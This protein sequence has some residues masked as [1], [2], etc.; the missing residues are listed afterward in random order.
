MAGVVRL[1]ALAVAAVVA[2]SGPSAVAAAPAQSPVGEQET[3]HARQAGVDEAVRE[4]GRD[5]EGVLVAVLDTWVD[6]THPDFGGRVATGAD[7]VGGP[8]RPGQAQDDC[9]HGTHVAGTV[10][11]SSFGVAPA[12]RVLPVRVLSYDA[13]TGE[14]TG[15]PEDVATG[16]RWAVE[17]GADVLNLSLGADVPGLTTGPLPAAVL[18]AVGAGVVVVF[19]AGNGDV[20]VGDAYGGQALVVA[21]TGPDG[22]LAS[23]SQRGTGVDLAAPGGDAAVADACTREDCVTSLFPGGRYAVAAGTSMAAPVVSGVA[24]LLLGQVPTR[25]RLQI[26]ERLLTTAR[27]LAEAGSGSIDAGAALGL[28]EPAARPAA[29]SPAPAPPAPPPTTVPLAQGPPLPEPAPLALPRQPEQ[30]PVLLAA[31]AAA[32]VVLAGAGT[33]AVGSGR[34]SRSRDG[35]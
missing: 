14:C 12:A 32:L 9:D 16:I 22:G 18:D 2:A 30:V 23:Y 10:A 3:W 21:A 35:R 6:A 5:G 7:C 4:A 27:P 15:R 33:A 25:T 28:T 34:S 31:L 13:V 24:A 17:Q 19:S 20:P 11:S 29:P 8:C 1:L 26:A